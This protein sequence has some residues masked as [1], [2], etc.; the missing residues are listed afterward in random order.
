MPKRAQ[1]LDALVWPW[2]KRKLERPYIASALA[3]NASAVA[4]ERL[5]PYVP[6]LDPYARASFIRRAAGLKH[7][8]EAPTSNSQRR[9]LSTAERT[10]ALDLLGD[11]SADVRS[12]AERARRCARD[13]GASHCREIPAARRMKLAR[14]YG[15]RSGTYGISRSPATADA[16]AARAEAM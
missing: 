3:A 14:A 12:A 7:R 4:G 5:L 10:V 9:T 2:W 13:A 15:S 6:D 8:W 11:T 1:T 16:F